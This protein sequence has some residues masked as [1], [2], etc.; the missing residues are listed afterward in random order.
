M[1]RNEKRG[2]LVLKKKIIKE[3][4]LQKVLDCIKESST[5][6]RNL[7][8]INSRSIPSMADKDF[9]GAGFRSEPHTQNPPFS[10][11]SDLPRSALVSQREASGPDFQ[12][13]GQRNE[14]QKMDRHCGSRPPKPR[15]DRG[16]TVK[17]VCETA[18]SKEK[19]VCPSRIPCESG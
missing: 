18:G 14:P 10:H 15:W 9:K 13:S 8:A 6:K 2:K 5:E 17:T 1:K 7:T 12:G 4:N 16:V 19:L 3:A 11:C